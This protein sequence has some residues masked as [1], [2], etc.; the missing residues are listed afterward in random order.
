MEKKVLMVIAQR[1]FR[2][3][4]FEHPKAVFLGKGFAVIVAA[5]EKKECTGMKGAT[6]MPDLSIADAAARQYDAVVVV[7]G[8]GAKESLW[9]NRTL[10]NI[11]NAH[12]AAG[13]PVAAICIAPV[14]LAQAGLLK[15]ISATV[16]KAPD[17]LEQFASHGVT[18]EE[19][20]VAISGT[21][22]TADGPAAARQF[23]LA[24]AKLME[25]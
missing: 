11:L 21:I 18:L 23:G 2:D 3:E 25:A 22:V 17:T 14:V 7:G 10:F 1:K 19:K 9:G 12:H 5:P 6:V 4:E 15:G 8:S 13:K 24:V 16:F 20:N